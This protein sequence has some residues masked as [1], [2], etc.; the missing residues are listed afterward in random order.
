MPRAAGP[1]A[2]RAAPPPPTAEA[3]AFASSYTP[4]N[5]KAYRHSWAQQVRS[6]MGT[7]VEGPDQGSVRFRV[8]ITPDGTLA[9]LDTVWSTSP[10]AERLARDAMAAMPRWPAPPGGRTLIFERTIEFSP[11][12]HDDPP[13][14]EHDCE[15]QAPR[16][17]NR[18]V[19]D[20]QSPQVP[21]PLA[22]P[23]PPD[24]VALAD[25]LRQ[26]PQNSVDAEVARDRRAMERWGW[27]SS[28]LGR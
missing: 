23:E 2:S 16:F 11:H 20:G 25:C 26:L 7:A 17:V 19:W 8:E 15:P 18:H 12:A 10:V 3:W 27:T 13:R 24:P 28:P 6:Q 4:R 21:A 22:P 5:G 1:A 9:R 14:Y